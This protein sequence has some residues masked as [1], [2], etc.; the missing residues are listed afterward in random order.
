[1]PSKTDILSGGRF[2]M[3]WCSQVRACLGGWVC[4]CVSGEVDGNVNSVMGS[5][6]LNGVLMFVCM[7]GR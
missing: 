5:E 1:M 4:V 3:F 7:H 2:I 6:W